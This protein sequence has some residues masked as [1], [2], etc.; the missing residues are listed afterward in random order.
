M[1]GVKVKESKIAGLGLFT[2]QEFNEGDM[3]GIAHIDGQPTNLIGKYHNH[4]ESPNAHSILLGNK[5]YIAALRPLSKGE[6]I[7]VDYRKQP[8]LEQPEEFAKG[9]SVSMPK[10]SKKGLASKRYTKDLTGTNRLFTKNALLK[11]PKSKKNRVYDPNAKY[12][13]EGGITSQ[14]EIDAAN[15]AMMKARLAYA[16]MH[17]NPAAQRMIVAP[18]Q[19]YDFGNG[20]TGTHYMASMDDYAVPQIQDVNGQ[21]MLGDY[22]PESAEA[23][24]FDNPEDAMYFA[25][26]YKNVS[27]AFLNEKAKGGAL[28]TKK[29]TCKKCGWKWDAA[30]GGDDITTCHKCGGQGLVHA[31]N[32]TTVDGDE[33]KGRKK[34]KF[35]PGTYDPNETAGYMLDEQEVTVKGKASNWGKAR[36]QYKERH[37]EEQFINKKKRQY[38]KNN[39]NL[40]IDKWGTKTGYGNKNAI[41]SYDWPDYLVDNFKKEYDYKTNTA[42]V[43]NVSRKEGW[44]PNKRTQYIDDLN[45]T[46]RDIVAESKYGSKLQPTYWDR[47]LAG[48]ATFASKFSPELQDAM[49]K[50]NMPGLTKKESQEILNAKMTKVPFTDIDLPFSIPVGGLESFS[51]LEIPGTFPANY[52]KNTGLS[53]G[54]SYKEIPSWYSGEKMA[55]VK[56]T[57]VTALNLLT[58]AGLEALPETAINLAKGAYKVGNAGVDL[59]KTNPQAWFKTP[60]QLLET[61]DLYRAIQGESSWK[62]PV[63]KLNKFVDD[64][65][66]K[67]SLKRENELLDKY[68]GFENRNTRIPLQQ[69]E[70]LKRFQIEKAAAER[71]LNRTKLPIKPI[72]TESGNQLAGGQGALYVNTLNPE[73]VI[74]LGTFPGGSDDLANLIQTGKDLE[75]MPLMENVAFP[76][77]GFSLDRPLPK[78]TI[79]LRPNTEAVQFMPWK[80]RP[81]DVNN[82]INKPLGFGIPSDKAKR[83]L[84]YMAE[85]LDENKV[86]IDYFGQNNMMYDPATDSYKIV[87]LNYVDNPKSQ[88]D[89]NNLDKP[90]KQRIEDKFGY[91]IP[92]GNIPL[93]LDLTPKQIQEY[94]E[95]PRELPN[96]SNLNFYRTR[97][98]IGK[99]TSTGLTEA[100]IQKAVDKNIEWITSPEYA[101]RRA[102]NTGES[103]EEIQ[104]STDKII[105]AA[106]KATY[107]LNTSSRKMDFY[108]AEGMMSKQKWWRPAKVEISSN[109]VHPLETL[110]HEVKHLYS[111]T[112]FDNK[113]IYKNYPAIGA[114]DH[115]LTIG[116]EQQVRHLNAREQI[117]EKNN[118]P[119]DAQLSE[120]QVADFIDEWRS[121]MN[122][123]KK[124]PDD[125]SLHEDYDD[126]WSEQAGLIQKDMLRAKYNTEDLDFIGKLPTVQKIR[127]M[128]EY[129]D[130]LNKVI[131][132]ALNNAWMTVPVAGGIEMINSGTPEQRYGGSINKLKKFIR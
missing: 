53:S 22:G 55:N 82:P 46:Q 99:G 78:G 11:K 51:A 64:A 128:N 80:G 10:A 62:D 69:E 76:T 23:I 39:K 129:T 67:S 90:V 86:G 19:P 8:E 107:K 77:K 111:P 4:S 60:E 120:D 73:E 104:K 130:R 21:L 97:G 28:L 7:T 96:S 3:I 121:K 20:V 117:L 124:T 127:F 112:I 15:R 75:G 106:D 47:T 17:G 118:L 5:R 45:D 91:E 74:K 36:T 16:N 35:Q 100:D 66:I 63:G 61:P 101:R 44:N 103:L 25:E 29:V 31:K 1:P 59:A 126:L 41:S 27:P 52:L 81:L 9:G 98:K 83:E 116:P 123:R 43:K 18:D 122:K 93:E 42:V 6:E 119:L 110:G 71:N 56:D 24:R 72:L 68:P 54:S 40:I 12:Y 26:N 48:L 30:D 109:A 92:E 84:Q 14:E 33:P 102:A 85:L 89:W 115:Y 88:F 108:G 114:E 132:S 113:K 32:G 34:T 131:R 79:R 2:D 95:V 87:D 37:P 50:G 57:D 58:Y 13:D 65:K 105:K 70:Q 49:N 38:L 125:Y 94:P